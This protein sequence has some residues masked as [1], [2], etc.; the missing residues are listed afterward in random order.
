MKDVYIYQLVKYNEKNKRNYN[1]NNYMIGASVPYLRNGLLNLFFI[2]VA[3]LSVSLI[4]TVSIGS[5]SV[6]G[7]EFFSR[8]DAPF[9]KSYDDWIS[10]YWNWWLDAAPKEKTE[11]PGCLVHESGLM[12]ML[13]QTAIGGTHNQ[14]CDISAK[15]GIMV[16]LWSALAGS[17]RGRSA[18]RTDRNRSRHAWT[19]RHRR[20]ATG[21]IADR[22][23]RRT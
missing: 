8:D 20:R 4:A 3:V 11:P 9:G 12:V 2:F 15:Q 6:Y 13:M 22:A 21:W 18:P 17:S 14:V 16:P 1:P 7:V 10:E 5:G 19:A 23:A